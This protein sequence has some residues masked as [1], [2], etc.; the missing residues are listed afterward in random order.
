[1]E[2]NICRILAES[3]GHLIRFVCFIVWV[4][5]VF[6]SIP[7]R[8]FLIYITDYYPQSL[9]TFSS[10][11]AMS[12]MSIDYL[13]SFSLYMGKRASIH[14]LCLWMKNMERNT[15]VFVSIK[16]CRWN[17]TPHPIWDNEGTFTRSRRSGRPAEITW[18]RACG[19]INGTNVQDGWAVFKAD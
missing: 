7:L 12:S 16:W 18:R 3:W 8:L 9:P 4:F 5:T 11:V 15:D 19:G 10:L 13:P 14:W 2:Y 1:M 17:N 6:K